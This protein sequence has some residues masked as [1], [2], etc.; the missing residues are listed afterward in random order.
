[1]HQKK[2]RFRIGNSQLIAPYIFVAPFILSFIIFFSY[3]LFQ[4][5]LMSFQSV[6]PDQVTFIGLDNFKKLNNPSFYKALYNNFRYTIYTVIVLIPIPLILAVF[7]NSKMMRLKNM[8]RSAL[9]LPAL[10]SVAVAGIIFKLVFSELD[11][12]LMNTFIQWLGFDSQ[13]WLYYPGLSMFALVVIATW[14][15]IGINI[16]YFL[17]ALQNIPK[18]LYEAADIDGAGLF[19]KFY[20][21]TVP[22]LKPITIYVLTITIYGGFAMFTESYMLWGSRGSPQD[23]GLTMVGYIYQQGF[24]YFDLGFGSAIGLVLLV[25]T[26]GVSMIQLKFMGLFGKE[27]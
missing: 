12:A 19:S 21:I 26:L 24:Q 25:I 13:K 22:L 27:D 7:L 11:G 16:L 18:E 8:F 9:F 3:P 6:L 2:S 1:M 23:I 14:R 10:T 4:A 20:K 5:I 15:W 17:S